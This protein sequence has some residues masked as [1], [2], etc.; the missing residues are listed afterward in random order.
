MK[1]GRSLTRFRCMPIRTRATI[2]SMRSIWAGCAYAGRHW[3]QGAVA[4]LLE[5]EIQ[6]EVHNQHDS[7]AGEGWLAVTGL[8]QGCDGHLSRAARLYG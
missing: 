4:G 3:V 5:A 2:K 7:L 1:G 8:T 6:K